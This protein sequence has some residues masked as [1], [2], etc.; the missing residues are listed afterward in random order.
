VTAAHFVR[1]V[2]TSGSRTGATRERVSADDGLASGWFANSHER[3]KR[4]RGQPKRRLIV[5]MLL[6]VALMLLT[7]WR[8]VVVQV[9]DVEAYI[10]W[11]ATQRVRTVE[12]EATRGSILDRD[13]HALV[14]SDGRPTI[15][16][17]PQQIE[18]VAF[19]ASQ[20]E[21]VLGTEPG[22]LAEKLA[23][24]SNFVYLDRQVSKEVGATVASLQLPGIFVDEEATRL[25]PN[26]ADFARGLLGSVDVDQVAISGL[27]LQY[28]ALLSG[29]AGW[30][31][32]ERARDGTSLPSGSIDGVAATRG[33]DLVLTIHRETQFL[34]EQILAEQVE[35]QSAAGGY[36]VIMRTATGEVLAAAGVSRNNET[37]VAKPAAYNMA[38]LDTYEPGSVNKVFTISAA[39]EA[40]LVTPD[41]AFDI[42]R[43]YR[44]ADKTF[45]EP[46]N[47]GVGELT[48]SQI[49]SK[50]S[51]IGTVQVAEL[52]GNDRLYTY[53]LSLGFGSRTGIDSAAAVPDE[54]AGLLLASSDW[55][56]TEL[57]AISFGQAVA[58]TPIQVA[59]AYNTIANNGV[60]VRPTLVRGVL[61]AE[62][63][64]HTW[65]FDE[66]RRVMS[67]ETATQV[68]AML[69]QV[70]ANGTGTLAA[71][72]GYRVAGK[73]GTAQKPVAGG[74]SATD[75][76]STFAG[77]VPASDPELT[78]VVVLDTAETYLAG[79][80]A[81]PLFSE[82]AGYALRVLRVPPTVADELEAGVD[83]ESAEVADV[84][85]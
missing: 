26:G 66:G 25:S 2:N 79:Q 36:A 84:A 77:F 32:Y 16:A 43:E 27:E 14:L 38:Y 35:A 41:T 9:L 4:R 15:W 49:V 57:A 64:M 6:L 69:E 7:A 72:D 56:G 18:D 68:T 73:T 50:S 1:G 34:A 40:G 61:D 47:T 78:I 10:E 31:T 3:A 74:Y 83:G 13:G 53:L 81:A 37:G 23:R 33:D 46:F 20:L 22:V 42:P 11:G 63:V 71:V 75:Y 58:L 29:E 24:S 48:V 70:V 59:A 12:I 30:E 67:S 51:N 65:P 54:S 21:A 5:L 44:F 55:F 45:V 80:V 17:D 19:V 39:L 52:L 8:L 76:M 82:L 28:D 62:G 85:G 60:Y